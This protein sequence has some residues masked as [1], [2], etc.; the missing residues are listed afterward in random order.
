VAAATRMKRGLFFISM[1]FLD[2]DLSSAGGDAAGTSPRCARTPNNPAEIC[3]ACV[4]WARTRRPSG[5]T[6]SWTATPKA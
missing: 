2:C 6:G 3:G 4:T 5:A 1:L